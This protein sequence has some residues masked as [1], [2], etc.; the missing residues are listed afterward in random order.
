[1]L[2]NVFFR[3]QKPTRD[4]HFADLEVGDGYVIDSPSSKGAV[5]QKVLDYHG[6]YWALEL[7][8]AKLYSPTMSPVKRVNFKIEVDT[9][10]PGVYN[11]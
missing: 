5:Y 8:T 9:E 2:K 3:N 4:L 1:M 7:A 10:L 6:V 11:A